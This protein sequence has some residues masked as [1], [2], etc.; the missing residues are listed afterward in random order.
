LQTKFLLYGSTG[1]LG[2]EIARK[3][4]EF[5]LEPIIAGRNPQRVKAQAAELGLEYRVFGLDDRRAVDSALKETPVVLHC[6]GPYK[7]TF[8]PML[9]G[10]LRTGTHYLDLTGEIAVFEALV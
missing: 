4:L 10:C 3:A 8:K 6:A 1:Y 9:D 2:S 5:N 7:Q